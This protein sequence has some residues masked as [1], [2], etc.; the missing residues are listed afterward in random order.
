MAGL[1]P[2]SLT[3][4]L[5]DPGLEA[6]G[7]DAFGI[8]G[9]G[10]PGV[11]AG[12]DDGVEVGEDA[13]AEEALAQ[14]ELDALHEVELRRTGRRP[15]ERDVRRDAQGLGAVPARA[16][17]DHDGVLVLADRPGDGVEEGPHRLI[18]APCDADSRWGFTERLRHDS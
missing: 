3:D 1:I 17:E 13:Q 14:P 9:E 4:D 18:P 8:V 15:D 12:V 11:A 10:V 7:S 16:V 2:A 6:E 5:S